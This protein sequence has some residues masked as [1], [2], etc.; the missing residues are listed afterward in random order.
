MAECQHFARVDVFSVSFHQLDAH[1]FLLVQ[2]FPLVLKTVFLLSFYI[3]QC[4]SIHSVRTDCL[5]AWKCRWKKNA[6]K[7]EKNG[8]NWFDQLFNLTNYAHFLLFARLQQLTL[9]RF[10]HAWHF[11]VVFLF[12]SGTFKSNRRNFIIF[13][14]FF[15]SICYV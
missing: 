11:C 2:F 8:C 6:S 7:R 1:F 14:I 15:H 10:G 13:Y 4:F 3:F 12:H 5:V 9:S